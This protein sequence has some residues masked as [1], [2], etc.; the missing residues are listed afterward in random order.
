MNQIQYLK[1]VGR[2]NGTV[3]KPVAGWFGESTKNKTPYIALDIEVIDDAEDGG[4]RISWT[5]WLSDKA[6][7]STI[8]KLAQAFGFNG[9]LNALFQGQM[10][11]EGQLCQ[12]ITE[13]ETYEG[14]DR[15]KVKW[16]NPYG[17]SGSEEP[18]DKVSLTSLVARLN[19]RAKAAALAAKST[20]KKDSVT[21]VQEPTNQD[22]VPF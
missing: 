21:A 14:K 12:F 22:D 4:K 9:D 11:F 7:D 19:G 10:T 2:F 20:M 1:T 17:Y 5:G 6:L 13:I 3:H 15:T 16:L 8:E 18:M